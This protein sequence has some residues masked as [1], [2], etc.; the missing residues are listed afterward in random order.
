MSRL[1][2]K[3]QVTIPRDV[4]EK[5]KLRAGDRILFIEEGGKLVVKK[6]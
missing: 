5:F 2:S 6:G 4:R 3:F 1:S